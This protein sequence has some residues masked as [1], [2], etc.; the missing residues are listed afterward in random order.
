MSAQ[1]ARPE[2]RVADRVE[3]AFRHIGE[4][5]R[6]ITELRESAARTVSEAQL[7]DEEI[8]EI[9]W[10]HEGI[11]VKALGELRHVQAIAR[12]HPRWSW[13]CRECGAEVFC[14]SRSEKIERERWAN[15][16]RKQHITYWTCGDCKAIASAG[17]EQAA[18][19][20]RDRQYQLHAMPYRQ[21][22][23]TPEW[24]RTRKAALKR[25]GYACQ[26]CNRNRILHVHH[27][28]YE[29]RGYELARDLIVLCDECH[30]LYH[31]KGLLAPHELDED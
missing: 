12:Q 22:L 25:A 14:A 10:L 17:R 6:Q 7:S 3:L 29:R 31:G 26:V 9:Y 4:L 30:A 8:A 27:R 28:T 5:E 21:Y 20:A 24:Q 1:A 13:R 19:A 18:D 11:P 2:I 23:R 15:D 16:A